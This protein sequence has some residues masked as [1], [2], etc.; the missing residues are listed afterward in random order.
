MQVQMKKAIFHI[1]MVLVCVI[2]VCGSADNTFAQTKPAA[3]SCPKPP[4]FIQIDYQFDWS[5]AE[6]KRLMDEFELKCGLSRDVDWLVGRTS[7]ALK[8]LGLNVTNSR[9]SLKTEFAQASVELETDKDDGQPRSVLFPIQYFEFDD[10]IFSYADITG[11]IRED[12]T[13]VLRYALDNSRIRD[14]YSKVAIKWLR[15]GRQIKGAQKSR[16]RLTSADV[17]SQLAASISVKDSRGVVYAQRT[18]TTQKKVGRVVSP[19]EINDLKI[20]GDAVVGKIVTT[21]YTYADRNMSDKEENSRFVWSRD[22]FVIKEA[23]GSSYQIVPQDSGKRISVRVTPR[24]FRGETGT[25]RSFTM[26]QIVEDELIT[27]RPKILAGME[28]KNEFFDFYEPIQVTDRVHDEFEKAKS[29]TEK[30]VKTKVEETRNFYLS[31]KLSIH[32]ASARKIT[33]IVFHPRNPFTH[34]FS[35]NMKYQ[36]LGEPISFGTERIIL[37]R[38][39]LELQ[40]A[41]YD[42][43]EA[44]FPKQ[45]VEDGVLRVQFRKVKKDDDSHSTDNQKGASIFQYFL[46]G[47]GLVCCI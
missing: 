38:L 11:S 2:S 13:V 6:Q 32:Y 9:L 22:G 37:E 30:Q 21:S 25:T 46:V 8:A 36:F 19:P 4:S 3:G 27:L 10:S 18:I 31:P 20:E 41:N 12:E 40:N 14:P 28:N 23:K 45:I 17:G 26:E 16:Y 5:P 42:S 44:Y 29:V 24:N 35:E 15:D 1:A 7:L 43:I 39:N 33:D 34:K 47:A